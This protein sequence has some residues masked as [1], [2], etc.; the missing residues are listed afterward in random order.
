[1]KTK[2]NVLIAHPCQFG[3]HTDPYMWAYYL[4][5][6]HHNVTYVCI[7]E[8]KEYVEPKNIKIVYLP[9]KK[10]SLQT[11]LMFIRQLAKILN[12]N[13]F[14]ILL[15]VYFPSISI[16]SLLKT[17]KTPILL[18]VRSGTI[19][20]SHIVTFCKDIMI[21]LERL[22]FTHYSVISEGVRKKLFFPK[23]S[24]ILPLGA[25]ELNTNRVFRDT[26]ALNLIYIGTLRYRDIDKTIL[27]LKKFIDNNPDVIINYLI[28]SNT[29]YQKYPTI[30]RSVNELHLEPYI[31][32]T[33]YVPYHK[34]PDY[35]KIANVGISFI[36]IIPKF[37]HQP[38]TKTFEYL[39][40]G[41]PVIATATNANKQIINDTN[42]VLI[43][44]TPESFALGIEK[45]LH[46]FQYYDSHKIKQ[47]ICDYKWEA[48]VS[49][50]EIQIEN[51]IDKYNTKN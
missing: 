30:Q 16:L 28:I 8:N 42:G 51:I 7:D 45:I 22:C 46:N 44:D 23:S 48:I 12:S 5:L 4:S 43:Q 24:Y 27:G 6:S 26:Q 31:K 35:L 38:P 32:M 25:E 29:D 50:L 40:A 36:P 47:S 10:T 39:L 2:R 18:D 13:R 21:F 1:M 11:K 19:S 34:L 17:G 37:D 15:L 33:G 49:K 41:I 20:A 9:Q 3:Y 14:D